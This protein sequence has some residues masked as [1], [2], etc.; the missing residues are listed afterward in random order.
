MTVKVRTKD[1]RPLGFVGLPYP[2]LSGGQLFLWKP[3][4]LL[5]AGV[6]HG[7][8][9]NGECLSPGPVG[10]VGWLGQS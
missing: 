3:L 10:F 2:Y 7:V 6:L 1:I 8:E 5:R 9:D 4:Q